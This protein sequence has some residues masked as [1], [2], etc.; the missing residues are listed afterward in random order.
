VE[1]ATWRTSWFATFFFPEAPMNDLLAAIAQHGYAVL[2][3][4]VFL[5]AIGVPVPGALALLTAGSAVAY[6]RLSGP[7]AFAAAV[8]ALLAG[9]TLL[10]L[11]GRY[12]GW[13]LLGFLCRLSANPESCILRSA[14]SFYRRGKRTLVIAKF[15]PALNVM[16]PPLAGSM[17]MRAA[18]FLRLDFLAASLYVLAYG[19]LGFLGS[20][21]LREI[22]HA[23]AS[24][25]QGIRLVLAI[26]VAGFVLYRVWRYRKLRTYTDAPRVPAEEVARLY[27]PTGAKSAPAGDP[28]SFTPISAAAG[29]GGE[30]E[31]NDAGLL[32]VDVRS[33]GYYDEKAVRI[34]GSVRIEPNHLAEELKRLPADKEIYLYCT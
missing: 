32:I 3:G 22:T 7:F 2:A 8:L 9:D 19:G 31:A 11:L 13:A 34:K 20:G 28:D 16:A 15:V 5:M 30:P 4:V 24:A 27:T 10:F 26:G 12:T 17:K 25:G 29:D 14:E 21:F 1:F 23:L 33:H 6:G 18:Q